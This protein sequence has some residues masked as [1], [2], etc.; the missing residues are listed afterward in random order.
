[1]CPAGIRNDE[2][3][4]IVG[5]DAEAIEIMC[6]LYRRGVARVIMLH[7]RWGI[8]AHSIDLIIVSSLAAR[9]Q[10]FQ[11]IAMAPRVLKKSGRL[12]FRLF[13]GQTSELVRTIEAALRRRDYRMNHEETAL[14]HLLHAVPAM[15]VTSQSPL[16]TGPKQRCS[17][18]SVSAHR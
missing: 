9:T 12:V 8:A 17:L 4:L 7:D 13:L 18:S 1:L 14:W 2:R 3:V 15:Q 11:A 16:P 5:T 10:I 6:S